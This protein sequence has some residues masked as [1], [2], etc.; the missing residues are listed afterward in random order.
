MQQKKRLDI[1]LTERGLAPSREKARGLIMAGQVRVDG[2]RVEK[3][4]TEVAEDAE[5]TIAKDAL[6]FVSRGGLKLD[7]ALKVFPLSLAGRVC[8]DVGASTGGFTDCMLKNGAKHVYAL[9]VGYGQLDWSLRNDERVAVMERRNARFME[10]SWFDE[11]PSFASIDVS[12]ISLRLI[13]PPLV[14][15]LTE[16][17][18][19]VALIKPQF[20][21]GRAEVGK[22]GVVRDEAVHARVCTELLRFAAQVGFTPLGLSF[23]PITG[24]KGNIEFLLY[25]GKGEGTSGDKNVSAPDSYPQ[26]AAEIVKQAH[27]SCINV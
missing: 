18:E 5:L 16:Q 15:C 25:L 17:A 26:F 2:Q 22:N 1:L 10:P 14:N 3:A 4:G 6:P 13:L 27:K 21:A 9:D 24:P 7:K 20:E 11:A 23:S 8:A 12:F 19:V